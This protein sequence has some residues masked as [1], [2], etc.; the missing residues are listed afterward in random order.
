MKK[1][2]ERE[3]LRVMKA[4]KT[5]IEKRKITLKLIKD[6]KFQFV[7]TIIFECIV[8]EILIVNII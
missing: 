4:F 7:G 1:G 6:I 8:H 3:K 5:L 2:K